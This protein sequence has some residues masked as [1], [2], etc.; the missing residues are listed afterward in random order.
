MVAGRLLMQWTICID[1]SHWLMIAE[2][3]ADRFQPVAWAVCDNLKQQQQQQQQQKKEPTVCRPALPA[4][5]AM[6]HTQKRHTRFKNFLNTCKTVQHKT[7]TVEQSSNC[8]RRRSQW[9][10]L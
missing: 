10:N 2:K 5:P 1:I 8:I 3:R 6:T 7:Q 9:E 4:K